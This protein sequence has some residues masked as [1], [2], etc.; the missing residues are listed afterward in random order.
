MENDSNIVWEL[1]VP[2]NQPDKYTMELQ[3]FPD[4]ILLSITEEHIKDGTK[5]AI[6]YHPISIALSRSGLFSF[7]ATIGD[8]IYLQTEG[9]FETLLTYELSDLGKLFLQAFDLG[10]KVTPTTIKLTRVQT[11]SRT[12]L[13]IRV[14]EKVNVQ[15]N[16]K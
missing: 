1:P 7:V 6:M 14:G 16:G 2:K 9:Q 12:I 15:N 8:V 5:L 10:W 3:K 13:D 11:T 4:E